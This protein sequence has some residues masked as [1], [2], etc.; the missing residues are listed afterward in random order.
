MDG[1]DFMDKMDSHGQQIPHVH[2]L[3]GWRHSIIFPL[4]EEKRP[5]G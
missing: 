3:P 1:M 2:E 4:F 5:L